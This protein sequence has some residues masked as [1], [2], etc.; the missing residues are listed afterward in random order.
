MASGDL[1]GDGVDDLIVVDGVRAEL[2]ILAGGDDLFSS[3]LR[4]PVFEKKLFRGGGRGIEPRRV[5]VEDF[6]G[7]GLQD[8]AILVHDRLIIYPQDS[9]EGAD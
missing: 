5:M 8:V 1:D 6:D 2:E 4:F 7:D 3:V 9:N